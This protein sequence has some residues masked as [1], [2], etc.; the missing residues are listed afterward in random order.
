M[1]LDFQDLSGGIMVDLN[2]QQFKKEF[3]FAKA[4]FARLLNCLQWPRFFELP[5]CSVDGSI[6]IP[7]SF[8]LY[9]S[10]DCIWWSIQQLLV[11]RN[12]STKISTMLILCISIVEEMPPK[13][14]KRSP[15]DA[16]STSCFIEEEGFQ[17]I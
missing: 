13:P 4:D 12:G 14:P 17:I 1:F 11:H 3:R 7:F 9:S 15:H 8:N 10:R 6:S 16:L 2:A 5:W